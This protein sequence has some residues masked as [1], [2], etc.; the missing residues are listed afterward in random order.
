MLGVLNGIPCMYWRLPL[1]A[2]SAL[3]F[4]MS[5]IIFRCIYWAFLHAVGHSYIGRFYY[6][7]W[8]T[9]ILGVFVYSGRFFLFSVDNLYRGFS[10]VFIGRF[11]LYSGKMCTVAFSFY[12]QWLFWGL[13]AFSLIYSG[14]FGGGH[15]VYNMSSFVCEILSFHFYISVT[16]FYYCHLVGSIIGQ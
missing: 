7:Q 12:I 9:V 14:H 11:F 10:F 8:A 5:I 16:P 13:W 6:I 4:R 1:C 15:F 2:W 3:S